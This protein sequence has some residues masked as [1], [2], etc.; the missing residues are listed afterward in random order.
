MQEIKAILDFMVEIEQLKAVVRKTR[1][2]GLQRHENSAEHSWHVCLSALLLK[3]YAN[4]PVDIH[5]V[6]KM[7]LIHDLGEID[8]GDT[9]VYDSDTQDIKDAELK[10]IQRLFAL[11]PGTQGEEL[12]TL[13]KEFE[14]GETAD[15][16]F[17]KAIDRVPPLLHNVND[18]GYTWKKYNIPEEKVLAL[19]GARISA[20]SE[21][22]WEAVKEILEQAS[23]QNLFAKSAP[24]DRSETP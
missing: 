9:I 19:N 4:E 16:R 12:L 21:S 10:G 23:T 24:S 22:L 17:A 8:A 18:N 6:M 5:R 2:V 20:G 11:L 13:W 14:Q 15:A 1:P 3:D 7:M